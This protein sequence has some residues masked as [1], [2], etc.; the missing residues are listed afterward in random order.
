MINRR[1]YLSLLAA[2]SAGITLDALSSTNCNT[3]NWGRVCVSEVD[4]ERFAQEAFDTQHKTQWCWAASISMLFSYYGHR[5]DQERIVEEAYG[6]PFNWAGQGFTIARAL[7]RVW[8]D[9]NGDRFRARLTAAYDANAGIHAITDAQI[10]SAL[11]AEQP[12][13][14]GARSHAM[15]LTSIRYRST[16]TGP[17][18]LSAGVF[19]P[20]PG[21]GGARGTF[22]DEITPRH[23]GGS[24]I[25]LANVKVISL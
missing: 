7:N 24:L 6:G 15:V 5:V 13:L 8:I 12:L 19:D 14:L 1:N 17:Q 25:F 11:H 22:P 10:V 23:R 2:G 4:F 18:I 20:W 9:D 16:S 21:N 3:T